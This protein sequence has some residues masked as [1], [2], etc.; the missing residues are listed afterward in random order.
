MNRFKPLFYPT[1]R[2][3]NVS[4]HLYFKAEAK[5]KAENELINLRKE[6]LLLGEMQRRCR[7]K[8]ATPRMK[9]SEQVGLAGLKY[10]QQDNNIGSFNL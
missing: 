6:V 5:I 4:M 1:Y 8:M 9:E 2:K 3:Y 7:E 10:Y